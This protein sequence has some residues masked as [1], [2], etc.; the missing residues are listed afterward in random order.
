MLGG[1][2]Y[3]ILATRGV[4]RGREILS[5]RFRLIGLVCLAL[6]VSLALGGATAWVNAS[7]SVRTEMRSA[8][9][10]GRQT[11]E[12]GI[13]RLQQAADPSHGLD[14][15]VA[16]FKGNRHLRV[17]FVGQA[18]SVATPVVES[19]PFG[20]LPS[21]FVGVLRV[22]PVI[23]RVP[24]IVG[25]HDYGTITLETDPHNEILEVWNEFTDGLVT[26]AVFSSLTILLIYLF[27]GR[28]LR[29]LEAFAKALE[30]VGDGR[31]STRFSGRLAPELAR[32]RDSFNRMAT[33]LTAADAENRR[34]NERLLTI[35][36]EE[37]S[38]LARDLHDEVSPFL[39]AI[40]IDAAS[41][42]RML[43]EGR[44]AEA[45]EHVQSIADAVRPMQRQVRSMLGRLRPIGLAEF[46]LQEAIEN[47]IA[48]WRRR[49]PEV[50]YELLV[51]AGCEGFGELV[52][53]TICRV[54]Q[55]SLSNALRHAHPTLIAI[56]I[57][58]QGEEIRV[59][60]TDDGRGISEPSRPGYGLVGIGE[61]VRALGGRLSFSN[62]P[63]EGFAVEALLP[64]PSDERRPAPRCKRRG[65]E[66]PSR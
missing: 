22:A 44:T 55:E 58:L 8:L 3:G 49:R 54:V 19:P 32:L 36:E 42:S 9:L 26:P 15:L 14:D 11:I 65:Y 12:S 29:P 45:R 7:R 28:A 37:R 51:S 57:D 23:D 64:E 4:N 13:E 27:I 10:V 18:K 20:A 46:G 41:A 30:Q 2:P 66:D 59:E 62:T 50:R 39:F 61:R 16:S 40:N 63:G 5:L 25:G 38:E 34:L 47:I 17:Q 21:W 56:S 48:F 33:R 31:Y 6:I 35:Q 53:R 52:G 43:T 60:I 24:V 1:A